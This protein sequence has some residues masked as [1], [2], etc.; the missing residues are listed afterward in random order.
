MGSNRLRTALGLS[1]LAAFAAT[2][3]AIVYGVVG[4]IVELTFGMDLPLIGLVD[5]ND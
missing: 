3:I 2:E 1:A 4:V 5:S